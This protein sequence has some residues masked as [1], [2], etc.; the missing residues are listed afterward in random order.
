MVDSEDNLVLIDFDSS[1]TVG[2]ALPWKRGTEYYYPLDRTTAEIESDIQAT[3]MVIEELKFIMRPWR[4]SK[5]DREQYADVAV[6]QG[7]RAMPPRRAK[8]IQVK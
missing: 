5:K 3:E 2:S 6:R 4:W 7:R 1:T 8:K